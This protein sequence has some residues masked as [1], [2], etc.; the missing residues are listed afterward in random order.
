M[1]FSHDYLPYIRQIVDVAVVAYLV[2]RGMMIIK[3]TRA[4]P[5]LVGFAFI[6][7]IY[8]LAQWAHLPTVSWLLGNILASILLVM[9]IVFQDE[10][11]RGLTK[12]GLQPLFRRPGKTLYDK[13]I[14]DI[15]LVCSRLSERRLGALIVV[16]REV[17]L[18]EFLEDAVTLDAEISRKLLYSI[19][20][21]DSPLHDGAV[22][23]EGGRIKAA[24]CLLPLSFNPDLDPNL[25][26][27]HRAALGLSERSDALVIIVSEESGAISLARDGRLVRN[28]DASTLRDSMHRLLA[29]GEDGAE[30]EAE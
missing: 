27:R 16:Q 2:Y 15:T 13:S 20:V 6:V 29:A 25:G 30:E 8:F 19:F 26:T 14:E 23:I 18:D 21:K 17:G 3:G 28:L 12:M 5:M 1:D 9:V 10:I 7:L 4:T 11:R 22:V 24:G